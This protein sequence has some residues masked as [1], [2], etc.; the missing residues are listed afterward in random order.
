MVGPGAKENFDPELPPRDG[1]GVFFGNSVSDYS[2]FY[3]C[4]T[5]AVN[6]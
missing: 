1:N 2:L 5:P 4:F 3:S 6:V